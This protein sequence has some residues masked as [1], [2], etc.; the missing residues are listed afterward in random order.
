MI[1]MTSAPAE[2]L[3]EAIK[4]LRHEGW[5]QLDYQTPKGRCA[6]GAIGAAA[7]IILPRDC[8]EDNDKADKDFAIAWVLHPAFREAVMTLCEIIIPSSAELGLEHCE[9][10]LDSIAMWNDEDRRRRAHVIA[11]LQKAATNLEKKLPVQEAIVE[12]VEK[13]LVAV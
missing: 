13:E 1:Q 5:I 6:V 10:V 7:G 4:L 2:I 3:R 8:T 11:K 9:Y 12:S